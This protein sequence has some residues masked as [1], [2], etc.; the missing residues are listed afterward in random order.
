MNK[1]YL[2]IDMMRALAITFMIVCHGIIFLSPSDSNQPWIYFFGNHLV[3][4]FAAP[5]FTFL[6][7]VSMAIS[8]ARQTHS[9]PSDFYRRGLAI[10]LIGIL[11]ATLTNGISGILIWDVLPFIGSATILLTPLKEVRSLTLVLLGILIL[12]ASG[13]LRSLIG[14]QEIWGFQFEDVPGI[15]SLLPGFLIDPTSYP[16]KVFT[17]I[18]VFKGWAFTGAFPIFPWILFPLLGIVV[19]RAYFVKKSERWTSLALFGLFLC[20]LGI[21]AALQGR[22]LGAAGLNQLLIAPLSF[23]PTTTPMFLLQFGMCLIVI[24]VLHALFDHADEKRGGTIRRFFITTGTPM[25]TF[26]LTVYVAHKFILNWGKKI[27]LLCLGKTSADELL[28][29][30]SAFL[31]SFILLASLYGLASAWKRANGKYSLEWLLA[32][33]KMR[34]A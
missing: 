28:S 12:I 22:S 26:S 19:G 33:I 25:S 16:E 2:S 34:S 1:R 18:R 9:N 29:P 3:G 7:G 21:A 23:Y 20:T 32:R 30:G 11:S 17:V 10:F 15:G 8:S 27:A 14:Y 31:C 13:P 4:D 6:V 24:T 5:F